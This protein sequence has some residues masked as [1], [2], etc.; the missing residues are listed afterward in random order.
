MTTTTPGD[1]LCEVSQVAQPAGIRQ[2]FAPLWLRPVIS[3]PTF[4]L[5]VAVGI[6]LV[7][8]AGQIMG[9]H[10]VPIG[11]REERLYLREG[12]FP[13]ERGHPAGPYH[14]TKETAIITIPKGGPGELTAHFTLFDAAPAPRQLHIY[15]DDV[16]VYK[17]TTQVGGEIWRL[18]VTGY[19]RAVTPT[20]VI[21]TAAW[22]PPA[23]SRI[24]GVALSGLRV[25]TPSVGGRIAWAVAGLFASLLALVIAAARRTCRPGVACVA[26][27][28][29]M[30][31]WGGLMAYGDVW[32]NHAA[33][34]IFLMGMAAAGTLVL[35]HRPGVKGDRGSYTTASMWGA[36]SLAAL[37]VLMTPGRFSTGDAEAM[38]QVAV[39]M[40]EDHVPWT[41]KDHLWTHFGLGQS[42]VYIPLYLLGLLWA[43]L[44]N[45]NVDQLTRFCAALLNQFVMPATALVLF[46]G[47]SRRYGNGMA[48]AITGS[49]LLA[50]PAIPYARLAFSEPLAGLLVLAA[51]ML[52][53]AGHSIPIATAGRGDAERVGGRP[54]PLSVLIAGALLGFAVLVKPANMIYLPATALYLVW[55]QARQNGRPLPKL[56]DALRAPISRRVASGL[57]LFALGLAPW[58]FLAAV[59]NA[60]R[61][62]SP[63]IT[64]YEKEG[65]TTP[66]H[67]GLY[68]LL[69]SPGKGIIYFAPPV[70]LAP[71]GLFAMWRLRHPQMRAEVLWIA[72]QGVVVLV[73]HALWSSWEGNIAWGPRFILPFVPF[74]L[75]PLG[76]L[77]PGTRTRAAWWALGALGFLVTIAGTLVD[78]AYYFHLHNVLRAGTEEEWHMLFTPWWSQIVA[79]WR[80]LL[81]ATREP[82][83]RP[84]LADMGMQPEW[85]T[86]VP[87]LVVG[88]A[89]F[90]LLR[91]LLGLRW[92][93]GDTPSPGRGSA[94]APS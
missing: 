65:F 76:A 30:G 51:L 38:F 59:F 6:L 7:L 83:A 54:G 18:S 3:T 43:N 45:A 69:F 53:W 19:S 28:G 29:V 37:L 47:A 62:G 66:L 64:G 73:F 52:L 87:V 44:T 56:G 24:L 34:A 81:T 49:F 77:Q 2:E 33:P 1:S 35:W 10:R 80:F 13:M 41:H 4:W 61:Y 5:L 22:K 63:L 39:G 79:H 86:V 23:D 32:L 68:G 90:A 25:D 27:I 84:T 46:W 14:W 21:A 9:H 72:V 70:I 12:F 57:G 74:L 78:M 42:L 20:L 71:L 36:V 48:L 92:G 16:E 40:V 60:M 94:P 89:L 58:L 11:E 50:T 15:L 26:G 85:D 91:A 55:A 8:A 75:W 88:L 67:V 93:S 82:V 31:L 17:G